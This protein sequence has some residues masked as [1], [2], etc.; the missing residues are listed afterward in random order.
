MPWGNV[1]CAVLLCV[2]ATHVP[3]QRNEAMTTTGFNLET[4]GL[5]VIPTPP[6]PMDVAL[7]ST[8]TT[9]T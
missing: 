6:A 8:S 9:Q 1:P 3:R 4:N 5:T 2:H 7:M